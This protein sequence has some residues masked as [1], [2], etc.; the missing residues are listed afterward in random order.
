MAMIAEE[1]LE[2]PPGAASARALAKIYMNAAMEPPQAVSDE[3]P[4]PVDPAEVQYAINPGGPIIESITLSSKFITFCRVNQDGRPV[5]WADMTGQE[6]W[7][8]YTVWKTKCGCG[9][10]RNEEHTRGLRGTSLTRIPD[11][12]ALT[13]AM[14][15]APSLRKRKRPDDHTITAEQWDGVKQ[16]FAD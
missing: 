5:K 1:H 4:A 16:L 13:V 6:Q 8:W 2:H 15:T 3:L 9:W 12:N 14:E 7:D 11:Q 10:T